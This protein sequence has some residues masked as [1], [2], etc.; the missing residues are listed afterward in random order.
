MNYF[1]DWRLM[2]LKKELERVNE[3]INKMEKLEAVLLK[4][5]KK[6]PKGKVRCAKKGKSYQYYDGK[7]YLNKTKQQYVRNVITREYDEKMV[8][9]I[10]ERKEN[11]KKIKQIYGF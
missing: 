4:E 1:M 10:R 11:L 9:L 8:S 5:A 7:K 6:L 3:E 2:Y